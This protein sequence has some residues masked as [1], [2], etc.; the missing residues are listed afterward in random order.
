MLSASYRQRPRFR[1]SAAY[2]IVRDVVTL[3]GNAC[4][5]DSDSD[6]GNGYASDDGND[7]GRDVGNDNAPVHGI[8]HDNDDDNSHATSTVSAT[9]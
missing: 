4:G 5:C 1:Y 7:D 6:N 3:D 8:G 2:G 9:L